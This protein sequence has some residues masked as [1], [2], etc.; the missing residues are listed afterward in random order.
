V[1]T[2]NIAS[3]ILLDFLQPGGHTKVQGYEPYTTWKN[4][5][6][7]PLYFPSLDQI[8]WMWTAC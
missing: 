2:S 3:S 1:K 7:V 4:G 5:A 8:A 6:N